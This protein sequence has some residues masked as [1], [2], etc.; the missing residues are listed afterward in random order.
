MSKR[1]KP[2]PELVPEILTCRGCRE[3]LSLPLTHWL[4]DENPRPQSGSC[5]IPSGKKYVPDKAYRPVPEYLSF[6]PQIWMNPADV[7][8]VVGN[9]GIEGRMDGCCG[10]DGG[11]GPNRVCRCGAHVG[12][13]VTDCMYPW[14]FIPEP[15]QTVWRNVQ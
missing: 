4:P 5:I 7:L 15:V 10:P 6:M 14:V 12:T 3:R 8:D 1:R 11:R 9:S 2:Q 13:E